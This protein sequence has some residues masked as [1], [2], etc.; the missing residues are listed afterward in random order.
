VKVYNEGTETLCENEYGG[1]ICGASVRW[2]SRGFVL[3][4]FFYL[5]NEIKLFMEKNVR[6]VEELI[7]K[8]G[9]Q[10]YRFVAVTA[11]LNNLKKEL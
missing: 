4:R 8:D 7:M 10:T 11:R 6:N 2:L 3:K 1:M 9:Q 5:L